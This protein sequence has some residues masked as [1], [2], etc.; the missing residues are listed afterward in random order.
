MTTWGRGGAREEAARK[1]CWIEKLRCCCISGRSWVS[2]WRL[3]CSLRGRQA[4]SHHCDLYP[5]WFPWWPSESQESWG[6]TAVRKARGFYQTC[7]DTKSID[8]AGAEPFLALVQKVRPLVIKKFI[9][10]RV[11]LPKSP[12][13]VTIKTLPLKFVHFHS[14]FFTDFANVLSWFSWVEHLKVAYVRT[15]RVPPGFTHNPAA[16]RAPS[17]HLEDA[18]L[19]PLPDASLSLSAAGGLGRVRP[20]EWDWFQLHSQNTDER[21]RH[22]SVLQPPGGQRP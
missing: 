3:D 20:V 12:T 2:S 7:L 9:P 14:N 5:L 11:I 19:S 15:A 1:M 6:S 10:A 8:T 4:A 21:L 16:L 18:V 22:F 17:Q 13:T